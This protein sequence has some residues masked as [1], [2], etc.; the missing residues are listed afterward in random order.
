MCLA[1]DGF[2]HTLETSVRG[3]HL[4]LSRDIENQ[5][6]VI[7]ELAVVESFAATITN[8][9][10]RRVTH[11]IWLSAKRNPVAA[12]TF[13]PSCRPEAFQGA[14]PGAFPKAR[15]DQALRRWIWRL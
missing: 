12:F 6:G 3:F 11:Y 1:E 5:F 4:P 15:P 13:R 8:M 2:L 14:C 7:V 9:Y 10:R